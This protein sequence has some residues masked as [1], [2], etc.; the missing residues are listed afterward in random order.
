M[1]EQR[2]GGRQEKVDSVELG[3]EL[4]IDKSRESNESNCQGTYC[5][6]KLWPVRMA[7][8]IGGGKTRKVLY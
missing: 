2:Q 1:M 8:N 7:K 4:N 3:D 5:Y 6:T